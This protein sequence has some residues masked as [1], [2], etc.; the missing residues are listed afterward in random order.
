MAISTWTCGHGH[1]FTFGDEDWHYEQN[2]G[3][4]DD[5]SPIPR[6][7]TADFSADEVDV[8]AGTYEDEPCMDSS[9]LIRSD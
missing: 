5:G 9:S 6:F 4:D 3:L 7:C 2:Q 1:T 8:E